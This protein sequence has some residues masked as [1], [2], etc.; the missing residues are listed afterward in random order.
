M[1]DHIFKKYK[2]QVWTNQ[3][4]LRYSW[5]AATALADLHAVGMEGNSASIS[6]TD[7]AIE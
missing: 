3:Q 1:E 6:H 5:Q 4:K 7:I 2:K